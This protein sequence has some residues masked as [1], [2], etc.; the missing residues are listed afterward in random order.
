MHPIEHLVK[1]IPT[2]TD[3]EVLAYV[4]KLRVLRFKGP[5]P[6]KR[7][8]ATGAP[9]G[10]RAASP[11]TKLDKLLSTMPEEERAAFLKSLA[12]K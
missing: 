1:L 2:M 12:E 5:K 7:S 6:V 11:I 8:K 4:D 3:E 10:G 9:S